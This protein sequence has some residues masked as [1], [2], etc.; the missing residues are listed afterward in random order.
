MAPGGPADDGKRNEVQ[1]NGDGRC[2]RVASRREG[3]KGRE[4]EGGR[5]KSFAGWVVGGFFFGGF[6]AVFFAVVSS[7]P[8][9]PLFGLIFS[10]LQVEVKFW[11][12]FGGLLGFSW[13]PF[14]RLLEHFWELL[15]NMLGKSL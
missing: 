13:D 4:S 11:S 3:L 7:M 8:L 5:V 2:I 14:G 1:R 6:L 9:G 12:L 15:G 10:A